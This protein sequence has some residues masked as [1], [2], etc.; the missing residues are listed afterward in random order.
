[1]RGAILNAKQNVNIPNRNKI[2]NILI[3]KRHHLILITQHEVCA[4]AKTPAKAPKKTS[5]PRAVKPGAATT[6]KKQIGTAETVKTGTNGMKKTFSK[7]KN[8][9]KVTFSLPYEAVRDAQ[10]VCVAGEFNDWNIHANS[11]KR[12]KDGSFSLTI[13]LERGREYQFRYLIDDMYWENDWAAD[14]YVPSAFGDCDNSV[15]IV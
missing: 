13:E 5:T 9:C 1:L 12:R 8:T 6:R 10:S 11:L 14:T 2:F 3:K 4:M 7:T 15:V